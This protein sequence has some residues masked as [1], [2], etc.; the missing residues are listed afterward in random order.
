MDAGIREKIA[1]S[2][3]NTGNWYFCVKRGMDVVLSALALLVL[4]PVFLVISL[5]IVLDSPGAGPFFVQTRVGRNGQ[6]F[7]LYKFRTMRPNAEAELARLLPHN[8]MDGPVFKMKNDPRITRAGRFLRKTGMDELPQLWNV[9]RGEMSLV[10][11]RPG[12]PREAEAY[13]WFARQ[14]LQVQPGLTCYWQIQPKRN[15]LDFDS[16]MELDVRYVQDMDLLTDVQILFATFGTVL[17]MDG[18]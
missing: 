1:I 14:R 15:S 12:L 7:R 11:P 16:W 8:E 5:I 3:Q 18:Q 9:L 13:D 2:R 6:L 4:C 10:G 17:R